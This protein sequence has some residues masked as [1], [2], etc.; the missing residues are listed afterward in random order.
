M[1]RYTLSLL[2]LLLMLPSNS[3]SAVQT[4]P[5][6]AQIQDSSGNSLN[7]TSNALNV[8]VNNAASVK[9]QDGAGNNLTSQ[10]SS[11]QRALD[12]GIDVSGVQVDPRSIRALTS[13]DVVTANLKD[14]AGTSITVGSK[15]SASSVPV[16]IASD[17][18]AFPVTISP[19]F[20]TRADTF[21]TATN[22]TT[23][24]AHLAPVKYFT[25][26]VVATGA[27]T[28]W[29][30]VLEGSL[31]NVNFTTILTHTN[32]VPGTPSAM[33]G[34]TTATPI[35]YFRSR[36]SAITLGGGTNVIATILGM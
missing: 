36:V 2:A 6:S 16:V 4:A 9:N 18:A 21:T 20:S 22:G 23:L 30:V 28:S 12:V 3:Q 35:L 34:G 13:T 10:A 5:V 15:V 8:N 25:L 31:D 17:Q 7:S 24:D 27:V 29:T 19:T 11:A 1:K 26:Q 33:F 14:S 32:L